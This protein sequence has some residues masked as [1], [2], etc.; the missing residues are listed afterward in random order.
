MVFLLWVFAIWFLIGTVL[1]FVLIKAHKESGLY[2]PEQLKE[3]A[4]NCFVLQPVFVFLMTKNMIRT[5]IKKD[6][7]A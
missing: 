6:H 4:F 2:E 7:A 3:F 5:L 1:L